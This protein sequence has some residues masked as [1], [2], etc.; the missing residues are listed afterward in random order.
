MGFL[1]HYIMFENFEKGTI[2]KKK[3]Q[4]EGIFS[5][6][7]PILFVFFITLSLQILYTQLAFVYAVSYAWLIY[8][9]LFSLRIKE[10]GGS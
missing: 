2:R 6:N 1:K 7:R 9:F 3:I 5:D 4:K 10:A 8:Y